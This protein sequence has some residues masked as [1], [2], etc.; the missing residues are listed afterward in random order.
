MNDPH[1]SP[2][3]LSFRMGICTVT[4]KVYLEGMYFQLPLYYE[5]QEYQ[6]GIGHLE[7]QHD[8]Q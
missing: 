4:I 6:A 7:L 3:H 2:K 1:E 8:H 5:L